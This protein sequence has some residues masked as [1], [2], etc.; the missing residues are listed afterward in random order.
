VS[1]SGGVQARNRDGA[2]AHTM[3]LTILLLAWVTSG[4]PLLQAYATRAPGA[5]CLVVPPPPPP[6][7]QQP[8]LTCRQRTTRAWPLGTSLHILEISQA[9][10]LRMGYLKSM[11]SAILTSWSNRAAAHFWLRLVRWSCRQ[12]M[13]RADPCSVPMGDEGAGEGDE[14]G[15]PGLCGVNVWVQQVHTDQSLRIRGL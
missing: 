12:R 8:S 9:Q 6:V 13:T 14:D 7:A 11:S 4:A 10:A 1:G 3:D 5:W 15:V 2:C